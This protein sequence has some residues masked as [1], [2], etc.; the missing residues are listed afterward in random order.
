M[1]TKDLDR[2]Q[3]IKKLIGSHINGTQAARLLHLSVRH[4]KRLKARVKE[5]GAQGLIHGS[6]G[7]RGNH[8]LSD[9]ERTTIV[10]LVRKH[11]GDFGPTF[12]AEKLSERHRITR[13][14]KT[15]RGIMIDD[16]LWK[17]KPARNK[18]MHRAWRERRSSFGEMIQFD[19]SYEHWF[20]NR[21]GTGEVCLLA[22]IDDATGKITHAKFAEH[23]GVFPVFAFWFEYLL[24]H[25]KP[26]AVYLDKF[27]TYS[28]NHPL[29]K[30]HGGTLT[31]FERACQTLR[32]EPI[33]ANSPQAKGRVERLF[34]TLQDRLVKELRLAG[35]SD[36]PA[37][38]QFL[39]ATFIPLFN[40]RFSVAPRSGANAHRPLAAQERKQ[41]PGIFS[42]HTSRTV[43]N[44]FTF[45]FKNQWYQLAKNQP[46]TVSKKDVVTIE[47]WLDGAVHVRLKSKY[48]ACQ[49]LPK[50][51]E[52]QVKQPWVLA[53]RPLGRK[54]YRPPANHPWRLRGNASIPA[55]QTAEV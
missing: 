34:G 42:K 9:H 24:A 35:I 1:S 21:G 48:L 26:H 14:A 53:A 17:P 37:A 12:A 36:I 7:K 23:E 45:S 32:M 5:R 51:P 10:A 3:I 31:Q 8:S 22:A 44:D 16:G 50:R 19:G 30:E 13:D 6:R 29:A 55:R 4:I 11:Y 46:A 52:K 43:L 2:F 47:E 20:E 28:M 41:L 38:N 39:T 15:I 27:S 40:A 18:Q 25:G 49:L 33:K 54:A